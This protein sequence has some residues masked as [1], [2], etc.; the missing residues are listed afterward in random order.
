M[1]QITL[2]A[3]T[4][5]YDEGDMLGPS[6]GFG[7]VFRGLGAN[8]QAVAVKQLQSTYQ[9][10]EMR[11]ADFL[12]GHGLGHV[13]P[14][15]DAGFDTVAGTNFIVMPIAET[16]LQQRMDKAGPIGEKEALEIIS[17]IAAGLD[18][19]GDIIHR[20]LK[21]GNIL[22]HDGVWKLADLGLARF[23]EAA[24]SLNTPRRTSGASPPPA[25][26]RHPKSARWCPTCASNST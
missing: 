7:A 10:R 5:S 24:T 8:N 22:L 3:G 2:P 12:L 25:W 11:I 6:G 26:Q 19:I 13:I 4:W 9:S 23:A 20:D 16:S 1:P 15:L 17:A 18:E 14:I 21:P